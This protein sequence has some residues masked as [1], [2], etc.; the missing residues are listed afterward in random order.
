MFLAVLGLGGFPVFPS[1]PVVYQLTTVA[2]SNLV[3]DG[4]QGTAAQ[5]AQ[6]EGL[7][8]DSTGNLYIADA[9]NHR[10][11]MVTPAGIITTIA[12][13]G[14]PGFGGDN[15]PAAAA[16]L[17]QPYDVALDSSGNLYIADFGNQRVR[18]IDTSGNIT[19]VAGNGA[20]GSNGDGG[21][22]TAA[23]LL[24]PRNVTL[25]SAGNLYL[26]EF[27]G[28]RVRMVTPGGI[29]ST[30]AGIGIAGFSGDGGPANAAQL[31]YPAGL[32]LDAAGNLY[33]VDTVNVRIRKV[34]AGAGTISSVCNQQNFGMPYVQLSGVAS[35]PAGSLYIPDSGSDY[36]WEWTP[37]AGLTRLAGTPGSNPYTGDGQPALQTALAAPTGVTLDSAGDLYISESRRVRSVAAATGI[38]NTIA[39]NGTF[40]YAGDG[41]AATQAVLNTPTGIAVN[42]GS[43]YIADQ[44]NSRIRQ[45]SQGTITTVAGSGIPSYS[46]DGLAA[47]GAG[48]S[49]PTAVALDSST[50]LYI[51]DTSNQRVRLVGPTGVISTFAGD[52]QSNGFGGEGDAATLIPLDSP[53]GVATDNAGNV[54]VA[55][56]DHNRVIQVDGSGNTHTVA[57]T[58]TPSPFALN[59]PLGMA[60]DSNGNLYIADNRNH[61]VEMLSAAGAIST[62]A[63]SGTNGFSGDGGP[64]LSAELSYPSA[65]AVDSSGNLYIADTGNNRIRVVLPDA[66]I[67][68]IAG[69]GIGA[70]N[71]DSG[72]ALDVALYNPAGV[73]VDSQG[74]VWIA[75][76]GNNRVCQLTATQT[77]LSTPP[78]LVSVT[79]ANGASLQPGPLAPGEIFSVFGQ[80][81][82]P[83]TAATGAFGATGL[84]STSLGGVQVMFN[85]VA[86][87]LFYVQS[88]QINAQVPY[89]LA[90]QS[91]AQVQILFQNTLR[92]STQVALVDANP[93]LFTADNGAGNAVVVNQDGSINSDQNPAARGSIVVLYATGAGE[94]TPPGVTGRPAQA[95]FPQPILPVSLSMDSVPANILFAGEAPGF[96]GLLQINALVPAGFV[97]AGDLPL[98]LTVGTDQSPSGITISVK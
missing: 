68:T 77:V 14:H 75:D 82:G 95:P 23:L 4:G 3:G 52:G 56:T 96:V 88:Q 97:P 93:A 51:A 63:G 86:A 92:A 50:D 69:T 83:A 71:A 42:N 61:R 8:I 39:G 62:V 6:P 58:G 38:I 43:L 5:L 2:G 45:V 47:I 54:Y 15:G 41:G 98:V 84:L 64:A 7:A 53:Q 28:H 78:Q 60:V 67:A 29:I 85:N 17:N 94:T 30:F 36:V 80:G 32:A 1:T 13:N 22:A 89:E 57:G 44:G 66:T 48:L 49:G 74:N 33:I 34:L 55:D 76:T 24:G 79:F 25:D 11:R 59:G 31:A 18:R 27:N 40:G 37:S 26:S 16:Q 35:N 46:G 73:A 87:P 72:V 20:T 19:T 10:V 9:A 12:G 81:I 90:G 91:A 65:V 21:P 70:Y